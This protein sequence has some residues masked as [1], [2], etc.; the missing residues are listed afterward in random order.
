VAKPRLGGVAIGMSLLFAVLVFGR[1]T[2]A[3]QGLMAGGLVLFMAG[4]ADDFC[5]L[6]WRRK[7]FAQIAAAAIA[8]FVGGLTISNLGNLLGLGDV[9][10][11]PWLGVPFTI[12]AIVG[13]TNA[14]NLLDGLDGLAAGVS[15]VAV[16]F[17]GIVGVFTWNMPVVALTAALAGALLGFLRYNFHPSLIF[18]G[19]AGSLLC[20]YLLACLAIMLTQAPHNGGIAV[21]P[22]IPVIV[23][24]LPIMDTLRVMARRL[25]RHQNP[26]T[27]DKTH[28]HHC[29]LR[30]GFGHLHTVLLLW[31]VSLFWTLVALVFRNS[32]EYVSLGVFLG[33]SLLGYGLLKAI[34]KRVPVDLFKG[35]KSARISR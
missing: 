34:Q 1:L 32:P 3:M 13:V 6:S 17:F 26:F 23:L 31:S 29:L 5:G 15:L 22:A 21:S 7:L 11:A 25:F 19:D 24:G 27:P 2:P 12:F 30:L 35:S 18:M 28:L 14:I 10:V 9:V 8:V 4:V 20:G 16:V 33:F